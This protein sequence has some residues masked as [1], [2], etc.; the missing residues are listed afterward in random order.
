MLDVQDADW[1]RHRVR[2]NHLLLMT[3]LVAVNVLSWGRALHALCVVF[4]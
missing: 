2:N 3:A 4:S 1:R